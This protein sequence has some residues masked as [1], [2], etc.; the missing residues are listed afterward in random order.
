MSREDWEYEIVEEN[1]RTIVWDCKNTET[2]ETREITTKLRYEK[3]FPEENFEFEGE[4]DGTEVEG[5]FKTGHS[6]Y[7]AVTAK[8]FDVKLSL[9]ED[10]VGRAHI[11]NCF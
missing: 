1:G 3:T 10:L 2:G 7:R 4:I 11:K 8:E 5:F 6:P 9:I